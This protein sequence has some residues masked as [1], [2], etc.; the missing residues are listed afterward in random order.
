MA[1][2]SDSAAP[3]RTRQPKMV[4]VDA[5]SSQEVTVVEGDKVLVRMERGCLSW[6]THEGVTFTNE[7]PYQLVTSGEADL[8]LTE[9]GFR[10]AHPDEL[11]QWYSKD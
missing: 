6:T 4:P 8:L 11:K 10:K 1:V 5:P 3:K 2:T 9:G 7:H